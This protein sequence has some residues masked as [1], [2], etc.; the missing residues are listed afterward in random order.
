[1]ASERV[2]SV[3]ERSAELAPGVVSV[4][5]ALC[6][7]INAE[8]SELKY[9]ILDGVSR[10]DF[11]SPITKAIFT[12]VTQM[13]RGG[14]FVVAPELEDVLRREGVVL[15][16]RRV[17]RTPGGQTNGGPHREPQQASIS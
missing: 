6:R 2:A 5:R 12:A 17:R 15:P 14:D 13:Y 16:A 8:S 1:M 11:R 7:T 3:E 10:D 4:L 9:N